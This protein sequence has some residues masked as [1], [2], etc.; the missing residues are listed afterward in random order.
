MD[1]W[2]MA[3]GERLTPFLDDSQASEETHGLRDSRKIR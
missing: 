2:R 3:S 1:V